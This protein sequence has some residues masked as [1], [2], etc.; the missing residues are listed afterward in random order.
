MAWNRTFG[1]LLK[2]GFSV[3]NNPKKGDVLPTGSDDESETDEL[4]KSLVINMKSVK[5]LATDRQVK[6]AYTLPAEGI[7]VDDVTWTDEEEDPNGVHML[8]LLEKGHTFTTSS[9]SGGMDAST[10]PLEKEDD[11]KTRGG[12]KS[13]PQQ[14]HL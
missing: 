6:I 4:E 13:P 11:A 1:K 14:R 9:W 10:M 12:K 5:E 7:E 2:D 8:E 3:A